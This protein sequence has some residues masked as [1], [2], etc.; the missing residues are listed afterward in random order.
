[1]CA[2][3]AAT[4]TASASVSATCAPSRTASRTE[5]RCLQRCQLAFDRRFRLISLRCAQLARAR[6]SQTGC[7]EPQ[8]RRG[9]SSSI[10]VNL[11]RRAKLSIGFHYL[12]IGA[13]AAARVLSRFV[14]W[15]LLRLQSA[16]WHARRLR[17]GA[18][19]A[20]HRPQ[21]ERASDRV[22]R[23]GPWRGPLRDQD[24]AGQRWTMQCRARAP[25]P[26]AIREG[27]RRRGPDA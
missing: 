1:M 17:Q 25:R 15:F 7:A 8:D 14:E 5:I 16:R 12:G 20:R 26:R 3:S 6:N 11:F 21:T 27:M 19:P 23:C 10:G 22:R 4:A 2:A 9:L 13:A 18:A 24:S